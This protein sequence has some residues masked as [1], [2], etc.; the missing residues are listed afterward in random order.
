VSKI[1][2]DNNIQIVI[3][4]ARWAKSAN[5]P[6]SS[7]NSN[8]V[9]GDEQGISIDRHTMESIFSRGLDRTILLLTNAGKRVVLLAPVP[10]ANFS[11]PREMAQLRLAGDRQPLWVSLSTY[12]RRESFVLAEFERVQKLYGAVILHPERTLCAKGRCM[13]ALHGRPLY[14][15]EH[16]LSVYGA[17]Q[18]TP[19]MAQAFGP[20]NFVGD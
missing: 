14:R 1:A 12:Q 3:L 11:V 8:I 17:L 7:G 18:L 13:L 16:H 5:D 9:T 15:D 4:A 19:V 2:L 20:D 10:E 6:F